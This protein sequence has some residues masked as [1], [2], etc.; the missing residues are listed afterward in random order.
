MSQQQ[1]KPLFISHKTLDKGAFKLHY[2]KFYK[3]V[4]NHLYFSC[5]NYELSRDLTQETFVRMWEQRDKI[6]KTQTI[7]PYLLKIAQ[8][9]LFD[10]Y[11][12][13]KVEQK[14]ADQ[15]KLNR[16]SEYSIESQTNA[17]ILEEK[18]RTVVNTR[19]SFKT[20]EIFIMSRF[21]GKSNDEIS[22]LL[23]LSKKTVE[24]QIYM[25]T[26]VIREKLKHFL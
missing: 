1:D 17:N 12:H 26:S 2:K 6:R 16:Q 19:L 3:S 23:G 4:F 20:K 8:N 11:R 21:E 10:F 14:Y 5:N 9:L 13:K 24:N 15:E 18:I 22:V 25:A 7:L